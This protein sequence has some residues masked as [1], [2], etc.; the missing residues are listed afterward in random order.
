VDR[1]RLVGKLRLNRPSDPRQEGLGAGALAGIEELARPGADRAALRIRVV[2]LQGRQKVGDLVVVVAE[3]IPGGVLA[4]RHGRIAEG[5]L[6]D[7]DQ[8]LKAQLGRPLGKGDQGDRVGEYVVDPAHLP[9]RAQDQ[10]GVE[11]AQVVAVAGPEHGVVLAELD[12]SPV[13]I[14]R[15][16]ADA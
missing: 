9:R 16:M 12:R 7:L 8:A 1:P 11:H 4:Q 2:T 10:T 3:R 6:L 5:K 13:A 15:G 14:E